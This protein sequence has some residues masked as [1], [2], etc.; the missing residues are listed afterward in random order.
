MGA[1]RVTL[2]EQVGWGRKMESK[3]FGLYQ[4]RNAN[5]TE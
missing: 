4:R 1:K 3:V 5:W 2:Q